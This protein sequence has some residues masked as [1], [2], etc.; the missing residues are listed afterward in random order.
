[1]DDVIRRP[2][3]SGE[4]I[5]QDFWTDAG[6][7]SP[8]SRWTGNDARRSRCRWPLVLTSK[9]GFL[10]LDEGRPK[11]ERGLLHRRRHWEN[12]TVGGVLAAARPP[13]EGSVGLAWPPAATP[14]HATPMP[15]RFLPSLGVLGILCERSPGRRSHSG[16]RR[17]GRSRNS[18][19][20]G[21][22]NSNLPGGWASAIVRSRASITMGSS[23]P[24][25]R[26]ADEV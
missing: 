6:F 3:R 26:R 2:R 13:A 9:V 12:P 16:G 11:G 21:S 18:V 19:E 25:L 20:R 22:R 10:L 14:G 8:V 7:P 1:M 4:E 15:R 17:R 5:I 24:S 23:E